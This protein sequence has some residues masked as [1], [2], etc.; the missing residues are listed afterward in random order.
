MPKR[1]NKRPTRTPKKRSPDERGPRQ[2]QRPAP[3]RD[4]S[5]LRPE[6]R[7]PAPAIPVPTGTK[8]SRSGEQVY[9]GHV[10]PGLEKLA[11]RELTTAFGESG[12]EVLET[13]KQFDERTSL[14]LFTWPGDPADLLELT[15]FED[16]F[17]VV[18][19]RQGITGDRAALAVIQKLT[20]G[21]GLEEAVRIANILLPGNRKKPTFRVIARKSG[22]HAYRRTDLRTATEQAVQSRNPSWILAEDARFEIWTQLVQD[23]LIVGL[24]LSD[25]TMRQRTYKTISL[26]A[27]LKPTVARAM[28][29]LSRPADDDVFL[30]PM[31]GVGTILLERA[32]AGRYA[33]LE[34]GDIDPQ[35]VAATQTNFGQRHKPYEIREW[36]ARDLPFAD[37]EISAIV[38][39]LPFGKQIGSRA[40][41]QVLYPALIKEWTRVLKPGG[42]M[43]LLTS[44]GRLMR[45]ALD[46]RPELS[47]EQRL[48]V[49]VRGFPAEIF[50]VQRLDM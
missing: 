18:V 11:T 35:A 48:P 25:E 23:R 24:R 1:I 29:M 32:H 45:A 22:E 5:R 13:L 16:V 4:A 12:A 34:G 46:G 21:S 41:N 47:F 49:V 33:K 10:V 39:N 15:L 20:A 38:S 19:D 50:V 31:C 30:D 42:R 3:T 8:S 28:V 2:S 27:S 36:N 9:I 43:V 7:K 40:D 37:G 14:L 17:A 26:P 6:R 44:E